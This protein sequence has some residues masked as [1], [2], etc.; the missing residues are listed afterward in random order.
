MINVQDYTFTLTANGTFRVPAGGRFF[1]I[2]AATGS[3]SVRGA[4][5]NLSGLTVGQGIS[6]TDF[7]DLTFTDKSGASN[8]I[9]V[10]I[11]ERNFI[12]GATGSVVVLTNKVPAS[13][14]FVASQKTV[15]NASAQLLAANSARQYLAIQNND[16][17][18]DLRIQFGAAA[19]LAAGLKIPAGATWEPTGAVPTAAIFAIGTIASNANVNVVEG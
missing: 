19:T 11:G 9:T 1:K 3:V 15:T 2:M 7:Q 14:S 8:T 5:G 18:G 4:W 13:A 10:V 16:G 17:S 6:D 12:D